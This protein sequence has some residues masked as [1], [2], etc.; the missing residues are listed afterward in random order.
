LGVAGPRNSHFCREQ[1][2]IAALLPAKKKLVE[3]DALTP[4]L[5]R[6]DV[7]AG[8]GVAAIGSAASSPVAY[9]EVTKFSY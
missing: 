8:E 5:S 1:R 2:S 9:L 3:G 6:N 4:L 7:I